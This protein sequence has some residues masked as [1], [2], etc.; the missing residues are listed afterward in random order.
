MK[1]KCRRKVR[2]EKAIRNRKDKSDGRKKLK[3]EIRKKSI[4]K[5]K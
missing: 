5:K 4:E 2:R 3:S 1:K